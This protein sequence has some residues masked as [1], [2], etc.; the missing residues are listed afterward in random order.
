MVPKSDS[1]M[2]ICQKVKDSYKDVVES[3]F[4]RKTQNDSL[5]DRGRESFEKQGESLVVWIGEAE[6][7]Q[8]VEV[9]TVTA[10]GER[11][12]PLA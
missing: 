11:Q 5:P 6:V 9:I 4:S 3:C 7:K 8:S 2:R 1:N 10:L 12:C